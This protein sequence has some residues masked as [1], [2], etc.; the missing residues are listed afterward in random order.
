MSFMRRAIAAFAAVLGT[1]ALAGSPVGAAETC[2][3]ADDKVETKVTGTL[4]TVKF[5]HPGNKSRLQ[6]YVIRLAKPVCAD[7]TDIDNKVQ[8]VTKVAR[9]QLAGELDE[10]TING[11]MNKRVTV[12]G[13]LFGQHTAYHIA[14]ILIQMKSIDRAK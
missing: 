11:H 5:V 4:T 7:V 8:R 13:T 1:A 3:K 6:A 10:K 14:P 2:L 12:G 9:V